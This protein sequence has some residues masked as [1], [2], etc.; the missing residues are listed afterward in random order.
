M[1]V[2]GAL[3]LWVVRGWKVG[4]IEGLE[5]RLREKGVDNED[6][7]SIERKVVVDEGH[8]MS[9]SL[10]DGTRWQLRDLARRMWAWKRV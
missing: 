4:E 1:Y 5:K 7:K 2:G 3:S 6:L 9:S 10:D 8:V